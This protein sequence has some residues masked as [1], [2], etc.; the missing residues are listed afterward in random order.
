MNPRGFGFCDPDGG[1]DGVYCPRETLTGV[2]D[3]DRVRAVVRGDRAVSVK[4]LHRTRTEV[5]G[6]ARV[7]ADGATLVLDAFLGDGSLP[8]TGR[9]T[10]GQTV[11]ARLTR[12]GAKVLE[13][14]DGFEE[15]MRARVLVRGQIARTMPAPAPAPRLARLRPGG[16][17]RDLRDLPTLTIDDEHSADL[18]DALSVAGPDAAGCMRLFVHIADVAEHV[19]AGSPADVAAR[20][21]ATSVYLHPWVRPMLP[22]ELSEAALSLLPGVERDTLTVELRVDPEG[23]VAAADVYA[24]RIRS[25]GRIDYTL[26]SEALRRRQP[27][28]PD[29]DATLRGLRTVSA[30]L[31][32][33]RARRG[34]L[35]PRLVEPELRGD[36]EARDLIERCMVAANEAVAVWMRDRGIAGLWR[37]H[38]AP[39]AEEVAELNELVDRLGF[40]GALPA[41][42]TP[43]AMAALDA[44][45]AGAG[46]DVQGVWHATLERMGRARYQAAP[47]SHFGLG[48]SCY[49][50]FTSPLRRYADL[51][52]HRAVKA[53]LAGDRTGTAQPDGLADHINDR[54]GRAA[55]AEAQLRAARRLAQLTPGTV[56]AGCVTSVRDSSLRVWLDVSV[57]ATV[58][59]RLLKGRWVRDGVCVRGPQGRICP[60]Q[61]MRF[62]VASVDPASGVVEIVP[63]QRP[64]R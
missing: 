64:R 6:T 39:S 20:D 2:L 22:A 21:A 60:G 1:G 19:P 49:T 51:V 29:L 15:S 17:R 14:F 43:R 3:G 52:V 28:A 4:V 8:L 42:L 32:T 53:Y 12:Q 50:H 54:A 58:P 23:E 57:R 61:R 10:D 63:V 18:D 16:A 35:T 47:G 27:V 31:Q 45:L 44:E 37:A 59:L 26:A 7:G 56:V 55:Q 36:G 5:V 48:S 34:G 30:R 33:S 46:D 13:R 25:D 9:C 11:V 38:D 40:T 24:S 62:T 41:E